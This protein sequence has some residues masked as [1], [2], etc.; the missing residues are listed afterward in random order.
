[1]PLTKTTK[2]KGP[3]HGSGPFGVSELRL[4]GAF[5][6]VMALQETCQ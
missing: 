5:R 1:M 3:E 6:S 2:A 4:D